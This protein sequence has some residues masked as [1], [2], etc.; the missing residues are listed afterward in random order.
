MLENGPVNLPVLYHDWSTFFFPLSFVLCSWSLEP[1]LFVLV[2]SQL[3]KCL[4]FFFPTKPDLH[5]TFAMMRPC[6]FPTMPASLIDSLH[7]YFVLVHVYI[8]IWIPIGEGGSSFKAVERMF[9]LKKIKI[10]RGLLKL[11]LHTFRKLL[12]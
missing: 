7:N 6:L 11:P 8:L 3:S 4:C 1:F 12:R 2:S 10:L 9:R 5:W